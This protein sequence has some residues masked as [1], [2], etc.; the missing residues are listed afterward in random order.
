[1]AWFGCRNQPFYQVMAADSRSPRDGKHLE[2]LGYYNPLPGQSLSS[3][4]RVQWICLQL[5]Y[6]PALSMR[7]NNDF[8]PASW[9]F[10]FYWI[11]LPLFQIGEKRVQEKED[12]E[13]EG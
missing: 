11:L 3:R 4:I 13:E 1:L 12:E 9:V 2:V 8:A 5:A 10:D 7:V 6:E